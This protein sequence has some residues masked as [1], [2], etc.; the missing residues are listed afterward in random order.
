MMME[1]MG[2]HPPAAAFVDPYADLR[3]ALS[4]YAAGHLARGIKNGTIKPFGEVL[5]ENPLLTH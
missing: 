3:E 4:C 2:V 5:T 1:M